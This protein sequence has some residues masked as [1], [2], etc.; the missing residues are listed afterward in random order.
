VN[1]ATTLGWS[2]ANADS[3][4]VLVDHVG[5]HPVPFLSLSHKQLLALDELVEAAVALV[6]EVGNQTVGITPQVIPLKCVLLSTGSY[7]CGTLHTMHV[8]YSLKLSGF[9]AHWKIQ[10]H[11]CLC[12]I[13]WLLSLHYLV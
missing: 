10:L 7:L 6:Q 5:T 8:A 3:A 12:C 11:I 9:N 4:L 1:K 2:D 13:V